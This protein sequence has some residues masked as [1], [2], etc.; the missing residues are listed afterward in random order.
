MKI[1]KQAKKVYQG[2]LFSVYEWPQKMFDGTIKKFEMIARQSSVDVIAFT[3]DKKI[4]TI[5]QTQP[6]RKWY[7]GLPGGLIEKNEKPRAAAIR[8]LLEETGYKAKKIK[9]ICHYDG[10]S[11]FYFPEYQFVATECVK[12]SKQKLDAGEKIKIRIKTFAEFLNLV[13]NPLFAVPLGLKLKMYEA[14]V[15]KNKY[16]EFKKNLGI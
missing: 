8:E 14:L 12:I 7:P 2:V 3:P 16:N 1:P 4:I 9:Q 15:D 11:K 13:R 10:F 5:Y 6:G